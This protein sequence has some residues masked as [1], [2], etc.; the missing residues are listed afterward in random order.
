M[1]LAVSN[2]AWT[3]EQDEQVYELLKRY[4]YTGLEI[5]PTRIFP[6]SP[7]DRWEEAERWAGNLKS[8]YGF[9]IPS[10]Q[11][12]WYGR[13]EKIFGSEEER[14]VLL[15]YT[16]KAVD[17]AESIGCRNL[18]LGCPKN[19]VVPG[20][21]SSEEAD[22]VAVT[23]FREMGDYAVSKGIVIS[24]EANPEI[25]GTNFINRT[26]EALLLIRKADSEG[27]RL[28]LDVGT[29]IWNGEHVE[30]LAGSVDLISHIHVSEPGLGPIKERNL[31][32]QLSSLLRSVDYQGSVS[33]EMGRQE[34]ISEIER[35]MR[36]M[37]RIF[38]DR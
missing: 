34:D 22:W 36:Y 5:A 6:D 10:M 32:R 26:S 9:T 1:K 29:M 2:I 14:E 4:G 25:Y 23:F 31:H 35:A 24:L 37:K 19:R 8:A 38:G 33:I 15:G 28:N 16:R 12:I 20:S 21:V 7:Y 30:E 11:S 27:F 13:Q 3:P 17:F 18:V